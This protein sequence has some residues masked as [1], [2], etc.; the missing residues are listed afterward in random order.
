M[1]EMDDT[2]D[3]KHLFVEEGLMRDGN[4]SAPNLIPV[5]CAPGRQAENSSPVF[6]G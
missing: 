2:S 5:S 3:K 1:S 4:S 6:T